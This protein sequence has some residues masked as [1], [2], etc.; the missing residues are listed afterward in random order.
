MAQWMTQ[1]K[2]KAERQKKASVGLYIYPVLMA[3][4]ILLYDAT[5]V[6]VGDDQKQHWNSA[7]IVKI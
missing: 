2:E 1:F 4:D 6:P 5:H 3:S 7:S